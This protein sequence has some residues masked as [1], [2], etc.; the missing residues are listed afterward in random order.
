M[1]AKPKFTVLSGAGVSAES[2]IKTFRDS[3][4]LWE[5]FRIEEVAT[6]QAWEVDQ[7]KVLRFYNERRRSIKKAEPNEAHR[8]LAKLEEHF[9]VSI[10]TQNIDDLHERAGSTNVMHLHGEIFKSRSTTDETLTYSIEGTELSAGDKCELGSQLRPDIVWFGEAVP[11]I[12]AAIPVIENSDFFLVIG[13]SLVVYPAAGLVDFVPR[14]A[15]KFLIDP[16]IQDNLDLR[17]FTLFPENAGS[18]MRKLY[19][20]LTEQEN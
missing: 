4:G 7:E 18:G 6:P 9:D 1:Q 20:K 16:K 5:E 12:E 11:M 14:Y 17:S 10:I 15:Q 3:E 13:T 19:K 2:G 8:L